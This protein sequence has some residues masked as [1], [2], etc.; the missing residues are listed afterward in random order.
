MHNYFS[1][2]F[3]ATSIGEAIKTEEYVPAIK[4]IN[5]VKQNSLR[6]APP[7]NSRERTINPTS[8]SAEK[9][10]MERLFKLWPLTF[11]NASK[12]SKNNEIKVTLSPAIL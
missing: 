3:K 6:V 10:D 12:E 4:P 11:E 8:I 5:K 1:F 7:K 9:S 2:L